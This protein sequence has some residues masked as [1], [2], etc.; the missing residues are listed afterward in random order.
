[1]PPFWDVICRVR[2]RHPV[3]GACACST[4]CHA[5]VLVGLAMSVVAGRGGAPSVAVIDAQVLDRAPAPLLERLEDRP[6]D[7]VVELPPAGPAGR[8]LFPALTI[9]APQVLATAADRGQVLAG[10]LGADL[11]LG[12]ETA[13][14][15]RA[16]T[17][18]FYGIEA[19]GDEFVFVVD[20]SGSMT[21]SRFR[22]AR[23]ELRRSIEALDPSQRFFIIFFNHGAYPMPAPG[24]LE[25]SERNLRDTVR[26]IK[27]V[28]CQ[29]YTNPL[30]A[31]LDALDLGPDAIFLLTDGEFDPQVALAIRQ[32]RT[33]DTI[34]IHTIAFT[35]RAGE[36]MLRA[37]SET[38]GGTYRFV[39]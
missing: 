5:L 20:M 10:P 12:A 8:P 29:G 35:S 17:A 21:G 24:L 18:D 9:E 34:P 6:L 36:P 23:G 39:R 26:W 28:E 11:S 33:G 30:P 14:P 19:R 13:E 2:F 32:A 38:T 27:Q 25:P 7:V 22:R 31:L 1:M 37:I 16:G 3:A 4:A 15:G